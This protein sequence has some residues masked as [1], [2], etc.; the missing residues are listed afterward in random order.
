M[1]KFLLLALAIV[2]NPSF[3]AFAADQLVK[4]RG[5]ELWLGDQTFPSAK[6]LCVAGMGDNRDNRYKVLSGEVEPNGAINCV[7]EDTSNDNQLDNYHRGGAV[8][9]CPENSTPGE[10][11]N[12]TCV[13]ESGYFAKNGTQCVPP[14]E[15]AAGTAVQNNDTP[16]PADTS[17]AQSTLTKKPPPAPPPGKWRDVQRTKGEWLEIQSK[18]S[19]QKIRSLGDEAAMI[20]EYYLDG[21]E[22]DGYKP[23]ILFEVKGD[24][25]G[26]GWQLAARGEKE[27]K[28]AMK[29]KEKGFEAQADKLVKTAKKYGLK[30]V[31]VVK[32][33]Q[34][35][36]W[37]GLLGN[38][39]PEIVWELWNGGKG[40]DIIYPYP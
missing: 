5:T 38:R 32:S 25:E 4:A 33:N 18:V 31:Y 14:Q 2:L 10:Y 26:L 40:K 29:K 35:D 28:K 37:K 20:K 1:K 24:Y 22:F 19:G 21:G 36:Y 34:L 3:P 16:A 39:Y 6:A 7:W 9:V 12:K 11:A 8:L 30:P 15:D 13:C 27:L 17:T 23:G